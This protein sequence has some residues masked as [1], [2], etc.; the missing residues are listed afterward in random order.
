MSPRH[1]IMREILL[2]AM[3]SGDLEQAP[4]DSAGQ[5]EDAYVRL[6]DA[7]LDREYESEFRGGDVETG[8]PCPYSRHYESK[9]VAAKM[10]DGSWVGWTYWYGGGKHGCPGVEPWMEDAYDLDCAEQEKVVLVRSF[11]RKE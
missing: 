10:C 8:L 5:V 1:K 6:A 4:L 3:R 9:A 7:E 2:Q 11:T